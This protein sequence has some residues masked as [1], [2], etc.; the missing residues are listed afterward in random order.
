MNRH[1]QNGTF[2]TSTIQV[3]EWSFLFYIAQLPGKFHSSPSDSEHLETGTSLEW[4]QRI[5]SLGWESNPNQRV[6]NQELT[7]SI[8][9]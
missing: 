6:R 1:L 2:L 4:S 8:G 7:N 3:C 5:H 9:P